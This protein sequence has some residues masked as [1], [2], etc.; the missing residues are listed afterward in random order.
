MK[1][2]ATLT[3]LGIT[4]SKGNSVQTGPYDSCKVNVLVEAREVSSTGSSRGTGFAAATYRFGTSQNFEEI[5]LKERAQF[6]CKAEIDFEE[7]A[8]S[9]DTVVKTIIGFKFLNE[10]TF[11][12]K[13]PHKA[14]A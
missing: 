10:V 8:S 6:P 13:L 11:Q 2:K 9:N 14:A 7:V 3:V 5:L 12:D 4:S 1:S